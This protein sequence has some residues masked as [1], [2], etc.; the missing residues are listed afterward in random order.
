MAL[1]VDVEVEVGVED[2]VVGATVVVVLVVGT[3]CGFVVT[4]VVVVAPAVV[5]VYAGWSS[6]SAGWVVVV[7]PYPVGIAPLPHPAT[8]GVPTRTPPTIRSA[9]TL[10]LIP[11]STSQLVGPP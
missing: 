5:V 8:T 6:W 4:I 1:V 3:V 9:A 2:V 7:Y 10:D 11:P